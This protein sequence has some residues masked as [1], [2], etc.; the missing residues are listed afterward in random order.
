M[1]TLG[2]II[3]PSYHSPAPHDTDGEITH[4]HI[5][6]SD[7]GGETWEL[8]GMFPGPY[9][10]NECQA[11]QFPNETI[12][13]NARG[14]LTFRIQGLSSD[15]GESIADVHPMST[16]VEPLE[17][18]EGSTIL[19]PLNNWVFY[20]GPNNPSPYRYNMTVFISTDLTDTWNVYKVIDEGR[21]AYSS[22]AILP[23]NE[24]VLLY[25]RSNL[26]GLI[27]VPQHISFLKV[28]GP[29]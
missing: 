17:G 19:H 28:W 18:C 16:L 26:T 25:E 21:S 14:I 2:R 3:T 12:L 13:V 5:M 8:G 1:F 10:T 6:Y 9:L 7:D 27:F 22:M 4:S 20:S 15:N 11:I 23:N 24:V 29:S